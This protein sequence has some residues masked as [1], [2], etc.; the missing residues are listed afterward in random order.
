VLEAYLLNTAHDEWMVEIVKLRG[1]HGREKT[2]TVPDHHMYRIGDD[3]SGQN[4]IL[5]F[6]KKK[7]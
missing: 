5:L 1:T 6:L 3:K 4:I 2:S 7:Q